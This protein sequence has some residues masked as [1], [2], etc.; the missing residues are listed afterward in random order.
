MSA[1]RAGRRHCRLRSGVC[2]DCVLYTVCAA[3]AV[4]GV[5]TSGEPA[6]LRTPC[7][8]DAAILGRLCC[9]HRGT[10]DADD[11]PAVRTA[12]CGHQRYPR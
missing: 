3:H 9:G 5:C 6:E 8:A 7:R 1:G 2:A 4:Y 10:S 12:G 11:L